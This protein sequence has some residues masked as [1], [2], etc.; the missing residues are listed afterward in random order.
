MDT[1][2]EGKLSKAC[3]LGRARRA[4]PFGGGMC[5]HQRWNVSTRKRS[6]CEAE[7]DVKQQL[8][9]QLLQLGAKALC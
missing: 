5:E 9:A 2:E 8:V 7:A 1:S 6:A 3:A 4:N